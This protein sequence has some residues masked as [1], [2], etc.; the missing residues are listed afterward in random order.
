VASDSEEYLLAGQRYRKY[1][2]TTKM[3]MINNK[4]GE[5]VSIP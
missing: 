2:M 1:A 4:E 5:E 3:M